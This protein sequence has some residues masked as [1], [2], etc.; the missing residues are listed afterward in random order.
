MYT[1]RGELRAMLSFI[2]SNNDGQT[3][4]A[5][6]TPRLNEALNLSYVD[7]VNAL[8]LESGWKWTKVVRDVVWPASQV[9]LELPYSM[10]ST[11]I[12]SMADITTS[13]TGIRFEV[14]DTSD[15]SLP[16]WF[17]RNKWQ[18]GTDGPSEEK[19]I[20]VAYWP[21]VEWD[22]ADSA[23]PDLIPTDHRALLAW[24]AAILLSDIADQK[25]P[26]SWTSRTLQQK[27]ALM[28]LMSLN[29]PAEVPTL[30]R[31]TWAGGED[32][33]IL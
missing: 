18:W 20:R 32:Y 23:E 9:V 22:S 4:Q 10:R 21:V 33:L 1:N 28:K 26:A 3:N 15:S 16:Y 31:S 14:S 30:P 13:T 8:R 24:E 27:M 12:L 11:G 29:R 7:L 2:L 5:F 25:A 17:D 19:T 6:S